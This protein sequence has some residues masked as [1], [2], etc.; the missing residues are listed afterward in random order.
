M[1]SSCQVGIERHGHG[2]ARCGLIGNRTPILL[3]FS[4]GTEAMAAGG[5]DNASRANRVIIQLPA[6]SD[7]NHNGTRSMLRLADIK[8]C[9]GTLLKP[10]MR[11]HPRHCSIHDRWSSRRSTRGRA[12]CTGSR[13]ASV[14]RDDSL[15]VRLCAELSK[16]AGQ[17]SNSWRQPLSWGYSRQH[18]DYKYITV[19]DSA[20]GDGA[21]DGPMAFCGRAA[22]ASH[23]G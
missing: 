21:R 6:G 13:I 4:V 2:I 18:R 17:V 10:T 20:A 16:L 15:A 14:R 23:I 9:I 5:P 1:G 22:R 3:R 8:R 11:L 12:G 7:S 19:D